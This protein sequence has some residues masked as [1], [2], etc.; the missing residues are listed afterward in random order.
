MAQVQVDWVK[1]M[2]FVCFSCSFLLSQVK[3]VSFQLDGLRN[4]LFGIAPIKGLAYW[5]VLSP[6]FIVFYNL[7]V[8]SL[9][10]S[11]HLTWA[12]QIGRF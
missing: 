6:F 3:R 1:I 10:L 7:F 11:D 5:V 8:K 4:C 12:M 9:N 2:V